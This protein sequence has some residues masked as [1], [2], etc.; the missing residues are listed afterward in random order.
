MYPK[1]RLYGWVVSGRMPLSHWH[2]FRMWGLLVF[3]DKFMARES[4][5]DH[6]QI[7]ENKL[8]MADPVRTLEVPIAALSY[9]PFLLVRVDR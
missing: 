4:I 3:C 8:D 2:Y 1:L 6:S 9:P 7:D 5:S